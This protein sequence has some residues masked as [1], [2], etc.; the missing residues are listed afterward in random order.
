MPFS[1]FY[2]PRSL[3]AVILHHTLPQRTQQHF[4]FIP[5][6]NCPLDP[7][8]T[9]GHDHHLHLGP[10]G[11]SVLHLDKSPPPGSINMQSTPKSHPHPAPQIR[12][13]N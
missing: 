8:V 10:S 4:Q 6:Y 9:L 11:P 5:I 2:L 3:V 1:E 7:T 12:P 13:G